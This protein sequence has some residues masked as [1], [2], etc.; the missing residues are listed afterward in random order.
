LSSIG[1]GDSS[2]KEVSL[3]GICYPVVNGLPPSIVR[4]AVLCLIDI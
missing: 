1:L 3:S 2:V 4:T